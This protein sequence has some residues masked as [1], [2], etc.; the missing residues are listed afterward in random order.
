MSLCAGGSKKAPAVPH[1]G[2]PNILVYI[3]ANSQ[4]IQK[5]FFKKIRGLGIV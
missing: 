2:I 4:K 5:Y 3:L 1:S